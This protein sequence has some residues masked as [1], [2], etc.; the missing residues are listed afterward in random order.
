MNLN[1]IRTRLTESGANAANN[2]TTLREW[3]ATGSAVNFNVGLTVMPRKVFYK[4]KSARY[5]LKK[6]IILRH[7][8]KE[9]L[10]RASLRLVA[11]INTLVHKKAYKKY[12]KKL[13]IAMAI[14]GERGLCDLHTHFAIALPGQ[15]Q[16]NDFARIVRQALEMSGEFEIENAN[17]KQD[18]DSLDKK[19]SYKLDLVDCGWAKYITKDLDRKSFNSIYFP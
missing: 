3:L 17:F 5:G 7:L 8:N 13:D 12:N 11:L 6:N 18:K 16:S 9:E 4:V 10:E 19:Y 2:K 14:E 1:D 15:V